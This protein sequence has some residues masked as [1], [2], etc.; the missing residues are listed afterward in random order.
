MT[1]RFRLYLALGLMSVAVI[2]IGVIGNM[3]LVITNRSIDTIVADRVVPLEQLKSISDHY[4]VDIVDMSH[5]VRSGAL[6]WAEAREN[7]GE[8]LA[9]IDEKWRAYTS[10]FLTPEEEELV[11][12]TEDA[13][14]VAQS[15][16][17]ELRGI[18]E[19]EDSEALV[20]FINNK[21]YQVIDPIGE[22]VGKLVNLQLSVAQAEAQNARQTSNFSITLIQVIGVLALGLIGFGFYT[23]A[24]QVLKPLKELENSMTELASGNLEIEVPATSR[25]DEI[26]AMAGT[27][28]V[29]RE[30]AVE[31]LTLEQ[32]KAGEQAAR[33]RR[34]EKVNSLIDGFAEELESILSS[35]SKASEDL[36]ST[37]NSLNETAEK[38][39]A[40]AS[41]VAA[42]ASQTTNNVQ[43]VASASDELSVSIREVSE[44]V[45]SAMRIAGE[46]KELT[47]TTDKTVTGL[48]TAA[49]KIGTVSSLIS[50][51]AEQT[52][53]LALNA[54]IEAAR[55]GEAGKGFA[56]VATEVKELASQTA[57]ATDEIQTQIQQIQ[58]VSSEAATAIRSVGDIVSRINET[59]VAAAAA[60]E[61]QGAATNEIARN[62]TEAAEGTS[63][64]SARITEVSAGFAVTE[65]RAG[66][67]LGAAGNLAQD[68]T[69][70]KTLVD[71]FFQDIRAA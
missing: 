61:E 59:A 37:A 41:D 5:K 62:V 27:V 8:A 55:A 52:N 60:V 3:A 10:T 66:E 36:H 67:L 46:A 70:L 56:V 14:R 68:S 31:R 22:P 4:A 51:I 71:R 20:A 30:S 57:R 43:T 18:F 32:D 13:T 11:G 63:N 12:K 15:A 64:V 48:V 1:I 16:I 45:S 54:T 39:S 9:R 40:N 6:T 24:R 65:T 42:T 35:V 53:L 38:S 28:Q 34:A 21:L 23:V 69:R 7:L 25:R 26:G 50:D 2:V 44:R 47:V 17:E 29:F 58:A 49:Q 33:E 19:R